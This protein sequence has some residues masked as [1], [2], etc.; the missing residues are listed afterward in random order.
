MSTILIHIGFPKTATTWLQ[1]L[2]FPNWEAVQY[3]DHYK[4][5]NKWLLDLR[6]I[7]ELEFDPDKFRNETDDILNSKKPVV[8]SIESLSGDVFKRGFNTARNC[9]YLKELFPRAKILITVR[10]QTTMIDS[11]YRQYVNQGGTATF[12]KFIKLPPP[13]PVSFDPGYLSFDRIIQLYSGEFGN[14]HVKVALYEQLRQ[15]P[16]DFL[17]DVTDF[18]GVKE[19][20]SFEKSQAVNRSLGGF[21][22]GLLR[23]SNYFLMSPMQPSN[24]IPGKA[25]HPLL[26]KF[27]QNN[28]PASRNKKFVLTP[29][30]LQYFKNYYRES[31]RKLQNLTGLDVARFGYPI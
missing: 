27:L 10:E 1:Q 13:K 23:F 11:L 3:I 7:N 26:R 31:N 12:G 8:I 19:P 20:S 24:V 18:I 4:P 9:R 15:A 17:K 5:E 2:V 14:D 6:Y 25:W 21:G 16:A 28:F 30:D 22:L 29:K